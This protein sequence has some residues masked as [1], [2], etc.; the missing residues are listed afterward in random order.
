MAVKGLAIDKP[1]S[2][3]KHYEDAEKYG[4]LIICCFEIKGQTVAV[5][6]IYG[7]TAGNDKE[8]QAQKTDDLMCVV[9]QE[10]ESWNIQ[11]YIIAGDINGSTDRFPVLRDKIE[12]GQI[13]DIGAVAHLWGRQKDEPTSAD[14]KE[15]AQKKVKINSAE[16]STGRKRR[17]KQGDALER[18]CV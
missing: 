2:L 17:S 18:R 11:H 13:I 14:Y 6:N 15:P 3:S 8:E 5:A 1:T 16:M 12:E 10:V 9:F 4:R 7:W